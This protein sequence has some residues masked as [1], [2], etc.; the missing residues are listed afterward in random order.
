M[1]FVAKSECPAPSEVRHRLEADFNKKCCY[2]EDSQIKG[3]V[4]HF[5]PKSKFPE[6]A[7][8]W[9]NLLWSCHDCNNKKGDNYNANSP[10]LNPTD[11]N[12]EPELVFGLDGTISHSTPKAEHTISVCALNRLNLK[13]KRKSVIDEFLRNL[14]FVCTLGSKQ[15]VLEY[16]ADFFITPIANNKE[17]NFVAFRKHILTNHLAD[18][19]R[20]I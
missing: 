17:L 5:L 4:E 8:D 20:N 12:P 11:E 19:L 10:I 2:C 16:I 3:E 15:Y 9:T 18:I 6:L 14:E 7:N 1:I 13:D